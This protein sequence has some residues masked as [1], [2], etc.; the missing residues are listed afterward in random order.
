M[1]AL[2]LTM[3]LHA[4]MLWGNTPAASYFVSNSGSDSNPG[5]QAQPFLTVAHATAQTYSAAGCVALSSGS[6]F[7]E[8]LTLSPAT[9]NCAVAYGSGSQPLLDAS[10][11]ISTGGWSKT[12]G[13]TN[14]YQVSLS[15]MPCSSGECFVRTWENNVPFPQSASLAVLD[16]TASSYYVANN[17]TFSSTTA[18]LYIHTSDGSNPAVNGKEYDTNTRTSGIFSL[19]SGT[20]V[21]G[22]HA[23][24]NLGNQGALKIGDRSFVTNTTLEDGTVHLS[25]VGEGAYWTDV[26]LLNMY[27]GAIGNIALVLN[28]DTPTGLASTFK[29][30]AYTQTAATGNE[31][32]YGH[33]NVSGTFGPVI[34]DGS[35][36]TGPST[37]IGGFNSTSFS[38]TGGS[39]DGGV[40]IGS[41]VSSLH[42]LTV[43]AQIQIPFTI[44]A[45]LDTV[46]VSCNCTDGDVSVSGGITPTL[47]VHG[48]TLTNTKAFDAGIYIATGST[49]SLT[50][51]GNTFPSPVQINYVGGPGTVTLPMPPD[52]DTYH[53]IAPGTASWMNYQGTALDFSGSGWATW[54]ALGFDTHGTRV[55][56]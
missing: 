44:A 52:N 34:L 55:A 56:P 6:S 12:G 31:C 45:E 30:M 14:I 37:S 23:R 15:G 9:V 22:L 33:T 51:S 54:Q 21:S 47:Y 3:P 16:S 35:S 8:M 20:L 40:V 18:T 32:Y 24:R 41:A 10:D 17:G 5:T 4:Q 13:F 39:Y 28:D 25:V 29:R 46:V 19:S 26:T 42:N 48:S 53:Y 49:L 50:M 27:S 7:H 38:A 11:A 1:T 43:G 2:L 36:C